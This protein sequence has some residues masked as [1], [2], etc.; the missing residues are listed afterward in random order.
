[1]DMSE[2]RHL[3]QPIDYQVPGNPETDAYILP[4]SGGSDSTALAILLHEVAPHI[5]FRMVF[6]DT[7][8]EEQETLSMLDKLEAY[9]GK[10]IERIR[11][12]TLFDLISDF[13]GFLP[14]PRD[15]YCTRE[16]KLKPFRQWIAQF[17]GQQKWVFVGVRSDESDRLAFALPEAETEMPFVDLEITRDWVYRKLAATIGISRSYQTRSRSGC[18]VCPYQRTSELVG[19]LQRSPEA[20]EQGAQCE[21][22]NPRDTARHTEG[23]ALWKDT[24]IAQNWQSLPTPD[25]DESIQKGSL[26]KAKAPD[27]FGARVFVGGE[28]FLDS[29]PGSAPFIWHQRVVSFSSTLAGIRKQLDGRYQHLL[30][31][32]EVHD[33]T[34]DDVRQR[35]KFAIWYV[36]LPGETFDPTGIKSAGDDRSYTWHQGKSYRQIRHVVDWATRVLHAEF[37]RRQASLKPALLSVEHEW[38]ESAKEALKAAHAPLGSVLLSEWYSPSEVEDEPQTEEEVIR[39][40]PCP[41][42]QL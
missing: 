15:R 12:N 32:P 18:T 21:K 40:V 17:S 9:L 42:C 7:G 23:V 10:P 30:S 8:A 2:T 3:T 1:M 4:V 25:S 20:F 14:S 39:R 11:G 16:L 41:M 35:A 36:E 22:L 38:K 6:T 13:S 37:Q 31:T 33:M 27:L 24:A 19:L 34:A 26:A 5:P 28:F 29:M